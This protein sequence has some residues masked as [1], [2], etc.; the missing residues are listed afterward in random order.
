MQA[1]KCNL[2]LKR[3]DFADS[4]HFDMN[5]GIKWINTGFSDL[6]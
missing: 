6:D 4:L 2:D 3:N 1:A 5:I